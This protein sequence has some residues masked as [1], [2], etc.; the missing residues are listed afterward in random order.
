MNRYDVFERDV[1]AW[2]DDAASPRMPD[3]RDD[4]L[5]RTAATRQRPAWS[6]P[7]RWLPMTAVTAGRRTIRTV[8]WKTVALLALLV[9][10]LTAAAV[11]LAGSHP[12]PAPM[13]GRAAN[14][15][16]AY[17]ADGDIFAVDP[18][19]GSRRA[20]ITGE[21][22]DHSP[23]FSLDG[24][25]IL[26]LRGDGNLDVPVIADANG[27][28]LRTT[29]TPGLS[30]V[31]PHSIVWSPDGRTVALLATVDGVSTIH[32]IDAV[33]GTVSVPPLDYLD[34]EL[35]WRPPDGR[36][37][38]FTQGSEGREELAMYSLDTGDIDVLATPD[39]PGA[40]LRGS[41][42]T[43]DG[44][45]FAYYEADPRSSATHVVDVAS[46]QSTKLSVG[47]GELSNDGQRVVGIYA[48]D[49]VSTYLCV[50]PVDGGLCIAISE[51]F[52]GAW[53]WNYR[54][55][56]D[57]SAILTTRTDGAELV[58]DADG[59]DQTQPEWMSQGAESWQRQAP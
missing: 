23:R 19:D 44:G 30:D 46:G 34:G 28:N 39:L 40:I 4:L 24:M 14:G 57:D 49:D 6:F 31:D 45:R 50:T 38:M 55:S 51:L 1:T 25:R 22:S 27:R 33:D 15:L 17:A 13:L 29:N 36:A 3:F 8:P 12:R 11:F 20:L 26:F 53:G 52:S 48:P 7:E 21:M 18:V 32:L 10:V 37:L 54:W 59:G 41:G 35:N 56:P 2:L 42:W 58:L 5:Q 16:V 9:L 47:Y 43:A